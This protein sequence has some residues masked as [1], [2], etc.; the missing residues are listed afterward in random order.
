MVLSRVPNLKDYQTGG[1]QEKDALL[2]FYRHK[3]FLLPT[4]SINQCT[5]KKYSIKRFSRNI[6]MGLHTFCVLRHPTVTF[7]VRAGDHIDRMDSA[8]SSVSAQR[9]S[10]PGG[11]FVLGVGSVGWSHRH[12]SFLAAWW[13][14]WMNPAPLQ[15][16]SLPYTKLVKLHHNHG[17]ACAPSIRL[18]VFT[19]KKEWGFLN[20]PG[21]QSSTWQLPIHVYWIS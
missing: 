5:F 4:A 20:I 14:P 10:K 7:R 1:C 16:P 6:D 17:D 19:D 8:Q 2:Q 9:D 15:L 13:D 21:G 11:C 12:L 3:I 18:N